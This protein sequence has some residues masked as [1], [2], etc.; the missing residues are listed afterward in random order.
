MYPHFPKSS[1]L[2]FFFLRDVI[3]LAVIILL[4]FYA[5]INSSLFLQVWDSW[6]LYGV[7]YTFPK[8]QHDRAE[9]RHTETHTQR[10]AHDATEMACFEAQ[11]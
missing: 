4:P 5:F 9:N 6:L 2:I 3:I 10:T 11:T 7:N 8:F 1:A